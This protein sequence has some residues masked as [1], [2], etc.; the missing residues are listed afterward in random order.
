MLLAACS[1]AAPATQEV[2]AAPAAGISDPSIAPEPEQNLVEAVYPIKEAASVAAEAYPI[3]QEDAPAIVAEESGNVVEADSANVDTAATQA[4]IGQFPLGVLTDAEA[5]G[6]LYM[7]EEEKLARDVYLTLF[8]LWD[9][10]S[11]ANIARSEQTHTD[12]V[13]RLLE[14]YDLPD[15]AGGQSVGEFTNPDLQALYDQ[16]VA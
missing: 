5:S 13:Q 3:I 12:A 9:F 7:R 1:E 2:E 15:P 10:Q 8:E 16:L 11:F 14:R 4:A 6:L